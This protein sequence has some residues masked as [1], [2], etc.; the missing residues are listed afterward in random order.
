MIRWFTAGESHGQGLMIIMEGVPAALPLSEEYIGAQLARRQR[1]YGRGGRMLIEQDWARIMTGVRHGLTL[2]SPIGMTIENKDWA[3]WQE[4]M[5]VE[6]IENPSQEGR[7]RRVTRL[8]PGH[9]D[10]PG[11]MKYGFSDVRNVLERAS[12]RETAA[13]VAAGAVAMRL[14]EEFGI[15]LY[16]HVIA[17]GGVAADIPETIDWDAV[18]QSPVRCADPAAAQRMMAEIDAAKEAG[19]T[20]GGAVEVI[21]ENVPIGIGSHTHWDKKID[22]RIAQALMSINA[23]KEV[24]IG[25]GREVVQQRGSQV[26]DVIEPVTDPDNPWQRK[27]NRAGGTEG[28]MTDGM[29]LV[30]RFGIKPIATLHHPLPSVDLDTGEPVQAHFERSDV[31]QAPPAGVI[32]EAMVALVLADAL[33]EKFGGDALPET[34]RNYEG[35]MATVGPRRVY[36]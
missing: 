27:T 23:V 4:A 35:Y 30:A 32:G 16:S 15:K 33:L 24:S 22:G 17:I 19:D 5:A 9:A 11:A 12:A 31:C 13:R 14:L 8:R 3:N 26:Q 2:G 7:N 36:Q 25:P 28:G 20:V 29:P 1:G 21:A 6:Y 18:E 10:L 34:R